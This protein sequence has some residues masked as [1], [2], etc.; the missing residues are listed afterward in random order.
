MRE[1]FTNQEVVYIF[2]NQIDARG[3]RL[4]TENEVFI[5]CEE[6]IEEIHSLMRKI[7]SQANT[8]RFIITAD[9]GFIY[10]R[11]KLSESDKISDSMLSSGKYGQRYAVSENSLGSSGVLSLPLAS[12]N[13]KDM[14]VSYPLGTDIFK[15]PGSGQ[16]F[17]H[18]GSSPHEL[19][20]PVIDVKFERGTKET[21]TAQISLVSLTNKITNLITTLD[22]IQTEPIGELVKKTT[23]RIFF[24]SDDNEKISNENIYVADKKDT[25]AT[26]RVFRLKFSFK[27]KQYNKS[28]KYYLVA[29]DD[30]ND[31]EVLR[32][33]IIMDIAFADDFGF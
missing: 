11:D 5:A 22:F 1:I 33:E 9:H 6:A 20:I 19:I 32:R 10:K 28:H 8:C 18:G 27:N 30:K 23:Y 14:F 7:S 15:A 21:T 16:N 2:H 25:D 12:T 17:V 3:D 31:I 26:K 29:Y 24:I 13:N 4:N